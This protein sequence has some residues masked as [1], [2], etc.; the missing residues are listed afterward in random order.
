MKNRLAVKLCAGFLFLC[1]TFPLAISQSIQDEAE[2]RK[3][4]RQ[5]IEVDKKGVGIAVGILTDKGAKVVSYGKMKTDEARE[6]DADSLFEIG[7]IYQSMFR[8]RGSAD[9]L[10]YRK[11][12]AF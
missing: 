8:W 11:V 2:I 5:R 12:S 3:I 9:L 6:V 7:S 1:F 10:F 4:L